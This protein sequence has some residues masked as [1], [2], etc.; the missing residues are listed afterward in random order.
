MYCWLQT[1]LPGLQMMLSSKTRTPSWIHAKTLLL[2]LHRPE[3]ST[4]ESDRTASPTAAYTK[5]S[6]SVATVLRSSIVSA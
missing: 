1:A 3:R 4:G 2:R 6:A 5:S